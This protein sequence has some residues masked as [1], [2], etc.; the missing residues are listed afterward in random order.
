MELVR[1]FIRLPFV[2]LLARAVYKELQSTGNGSSS[3]FLTFGDP[4][5]AEFSMALYSTDQRL[6]YTD[7]QMDNFIQNWL[8]MG[9]NVGKQARHR[10]AAVRRL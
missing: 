9:Q 4:S 5:R 2:C 10:L 7:K 8:K 3:R 1:Y 6:C